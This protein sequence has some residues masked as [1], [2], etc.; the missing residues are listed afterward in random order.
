MQREDPWYHYEGDIYVKE[1]Y[2]PKE[3]EMKDCDPEPSP[4]KKKKPKRV[5]PTSRAHHE[6]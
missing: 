5:G 4:P 3:E 6:E 2:L 1:V